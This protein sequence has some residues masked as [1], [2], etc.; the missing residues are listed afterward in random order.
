MQRPIKGPEV[1]AQFRRPRTSKQAR[2]YPVE[3]CEVFQGDNSLGEAGF[4]WL[5][6]CGRAGQ[7][8]KAGTQTGA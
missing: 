2:S 3:R 1:T 8:S 7:G 6:I 5:V 4:I